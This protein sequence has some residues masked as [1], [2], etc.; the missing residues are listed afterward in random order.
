M[1]QPQP[2]NPFTKGQDQSKVVAWFASLEKCPGW[3]DWIRP[4]LLQRYTTAKTS[5]LESALKGTETPPDHLADY[6]ALHPL[7]DMLDRQQA[8]ATAQAQSS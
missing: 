5:I 4:H 8:I 6:R 3:K 2:D 1:S 7:F